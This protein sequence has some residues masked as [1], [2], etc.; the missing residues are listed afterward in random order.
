MKRINQVSKT[1][2]KKCNLTYDWKWEGVLYRFEI[3]SVS[4]FKDLKNV[5]QVYGVIMDRKDKVLIVRGDSH[6]G[7]ILPGG[8]IE[9]GESY[10]DTLK[11]EV[12][13]EAAVYLDEFTIE[14]F[15]YQTVYVK[16]GNE[17]K[18]HQNQIRYFARMDSKE[19]FV[20]DPDESDIVDQKF[21]KAENLDKYL[22]WGNIVSFM[23]NKLKRF[24]S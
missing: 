7:W 20:K 1:Q 22:K 17:W 12:Y 3:Y 6:D 4:T 9:K 10:I 23:K 11:R 2:R 15:F 5:K 21:V 13:E 24:K 8:A 19:T 16:I 18:F 14:P